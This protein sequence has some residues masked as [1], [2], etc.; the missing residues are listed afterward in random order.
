MPI[1]LDGFIASNAI[2]SLDI[3]GNRLNAEFLF[4]Y[5]SRKSYYLRIGHIMDGTGQKELS[6]KQ[7]MNL[8]ISAPPIAEQ[9]RVVNVL[10][11][12][13]KEITMLEQLA[14]SYRTQKRGLMQKL[15]TGKWRIRNQIAR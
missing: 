8:P 9:D 12:A 14:K 10:N 13:R 5:F 15:L 3:D 2:T 1:E 4:Y 7:I 6:D 11:T